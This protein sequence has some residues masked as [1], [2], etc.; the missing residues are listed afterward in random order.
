M[1]A[2]AGDVSPHVYFPTSA[3]ISLIASVKD[4]PGIQVGLIG[5][6][7]AFGSPLLAGLPLAPLQ[8]RALTAGWVWRVGAIA[9]REELVRSG[10]LRQML[11]RYLHVLLM[12][13][14]QVAACT[15]YHSVEE[16]LARWLLTARDRVRSDSFRLKHQVMA[17]MLGVQRSGISLAAMRLKRSG[18]VRYSRGLI[19]IT[20]PEGLQHAACDCYRWA[21]HCHNSLMGEGP[22]G[23]KNGG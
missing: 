1:L 5:G 4:T 7:G 21:E 11:N 20:D 23:E 3:A 14:S 12:Q 16:R 17:D 19:T 13:T 22:G 10:A 9:L 6:E 8:A 2:E 15:R 18:L